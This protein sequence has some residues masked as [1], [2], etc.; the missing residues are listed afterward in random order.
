VE[1]FNAK[2]YVCTAC[3]FLERL[4]PRVT[5]QRLMGE[6]IGGEALIAPR[7]PESKARVASM[8]EEEFRRRGTTQGARYALRSPAT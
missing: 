3:D 5:V 6:T 7:W 2:D 4:P 8:I 1:L